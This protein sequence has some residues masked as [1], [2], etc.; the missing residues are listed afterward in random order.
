[1]SLRQNKRSRDRQGTVSPLQESGP[2][3][4][5]RPTQ[6]NQNPRVFDRAKA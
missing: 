1:M 4:S 5:L 6:G 3:T 2:V